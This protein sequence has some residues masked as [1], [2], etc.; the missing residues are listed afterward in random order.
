VANPL[1]SLP[2]PTLAG[3]IDPMGQPVGTWTLKFDD[4]FNASTVNTIDAPN[5]LVKFG[6]GPTWQAW[7]PSA[8]VGDGN[9]HTNNPGTEIEYYD[10]TGLSVGSGIL[11]LTATHNN[12]HA[13]FA[14]TSGMI[15]SNPS[16]NPKFGYAEARIKS[17]AVAGSWPAFW[18]IPSSYKWPPE[19]DIY[20]NFSDPGFYKASNF[21]GGTVFGNQ[22][23]TDVK[24]WHTY[25]L[26]WTATQL[27][28]YLDGAQVASEGKASAIPQEPMYI[29][30]NLAVT[31]T[32][33]PAFGAQLDY[34]RFWQ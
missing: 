16:F 21:G 30:A 34:I 19:V 9:A 17:P 2:T 28:W 23:N 12:A 29:V 33:T 11:N 15:T 24:Q 4:E 18:M 5:G 1:S 27:I 8:L 7:Y 31:N 20:E 10:I 14:Y 6:S 32:S 26:K 25:G 13:G 3:S 22:I